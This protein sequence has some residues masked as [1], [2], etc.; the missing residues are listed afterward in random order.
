[1]PL[2]KD[3]NRD[4]NF[5]LLPEHKPSSWP[6]PF[7]PEGSPKEVDDHNS[8]SRPVSDILDYYLKPL[9]SMHKS[10]TNDSYD[11]LNKI[12]NKEIQGDIYWHPEMFFP[13]IQI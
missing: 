6:D 9:A 11:F 10:Y 4:R 5:Y 2:T 1:M 7:M 8:E 13:C 12:L 3:S